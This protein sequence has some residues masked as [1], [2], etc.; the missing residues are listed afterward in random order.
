[1][2]ELASDY[3]FQTSEA[4]H[5]PTSS[6]TEATRQYLFEVIVYD[7]HWTA[8]QIG[9]IT[10]LFSACAKAAGQWSLHSS[11][12]M[13][14][15]DTRAGLLGLKYSA[16]IGMPD[17]SSK[18]IERTYLELRN[19]KAASKNI[20]ESKALRGA[21]QERALLKLAA[22]W[23]DVSHTTLYA[24]RAIEPV[25]K[26]RMSDLHSKNCQ[27]LT[28]FLEEAGSGSTERVG[29]LG[30]ITLPRLAEWRRAPRVVKSET[31]TLLVQGTA[32]PATLRD[33]SRYGLGIECGHPVSDSEIVAVELPNRRPMQASVAWHKGGRIGL[34]LLIPLDFTDHL[35]F[36]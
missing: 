27:V 18:A 14:E 35:L 31:C 16:E 1:M 22:Q 10:C 32:V 21:N 23:R 29:P 3:G 25:A 8:M 7:L 12:H 9:T 36:E 19:A 24:L 5:C 17:E 28:R 20:V 34:R 30:E 2:S 15:D 26:K 13:L 11:H 33:V 6:L 4:T